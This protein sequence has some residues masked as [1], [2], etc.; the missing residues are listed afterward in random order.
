[1]LVPFGRGC[2]GCHQLHT[3]P[4]LIDWL[5]IRHQ[6]WWMCPLLRIL[7]NNRPFVASRTGSEPPTKL[8]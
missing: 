5:L 6:A 8:V 4:C 7:S 1:M 2:D 3:P